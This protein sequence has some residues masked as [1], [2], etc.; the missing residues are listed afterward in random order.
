MNRETLSVLVLE[1]NA[2]QCDLIKMALIRNRMNPI[3]CNE[4][5]RLRQH[6]IE[7]MPDVLL[8]DTYLPGQNGLD[9]IGELNS[10]IL[11]KRT[12][13]FFISSLGFPEI[14][15]KAVQMGASGFLVKPLNPDLL[16]TRIQNCFKQPRQ[17][18]S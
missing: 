4:P 3:I 1:P 13:V 17:F 8:I 10:E 7:L 14:V 9:L 12:K 6:L 15:Q 16:I 2:L 5:S 11:L 18:P